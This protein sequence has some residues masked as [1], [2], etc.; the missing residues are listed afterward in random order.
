MA[1][2][3]RNAEVRDE[4]VPLLYELCGVPQTI[5]FLYLITLPFMTDPRIYVGFTGNPYG[6]SPE[7]VMRTGRGIANAGYCD[8]KRGLVSPRYQVPSTFI[9]NVV[10]DIHMCQD[11]F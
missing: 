9:N 1:R 4:F 7:R 8:H 10:L 3:L 6:L 2:S 5:L 11:H